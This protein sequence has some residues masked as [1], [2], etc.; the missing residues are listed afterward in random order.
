MLSRTRSPVAL[1]AVVA[2]FFVYYYSCISP[3]QLSSDQFFLGPPL[4][5]TTGHFVDPNLRFE[6]TYLKPPGSTYNRTLV[7]GHRKQDSI[8]WISETLPDIDVAAYVVDDLAAPL[9]TPR[10]KGRE[11]MVYLTYIIHHY[12]KLPDIV[13]FFHAGQY[14]WHNNVWHDRDSVQMIRAMRDD[15]IVR[16]GYFNARCELRPGCPDWI[17]IDRPEI[18]FDPVYKPE[19]KAYTAQVWRQIWGS[20]ARV[21]QALSQP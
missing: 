20:T 18:D 13:L 19:E 6:R 16:E 11:A 1:W 5:S 15:H 12:E 17:H 7:I 14:A 21:P 10:N 8:A 2:T 9:H 3:A 4:N